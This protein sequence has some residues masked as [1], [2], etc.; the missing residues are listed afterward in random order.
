MSKIGTFREYL[1]EAKIEKE[2]NEASAGIKNLS[3]N[4]IKTIKIISILS[5][6]FSKIITHSN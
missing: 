4:E 1:A 5:K 3:D 6:F 2:V